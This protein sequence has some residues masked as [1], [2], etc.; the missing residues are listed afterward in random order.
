MRRAVSLFLAAILTSCG[1]APAFAETLTASY[2]GA[3]SGRRTASGETFRP[4]GL[5]A[6]HRTLAFGTRLRVCRAERCVSVRVT[7]RGPFVRGRALDLSAG[8]ARAIGLTGIGVGRVE[9]TRE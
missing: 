2:Y 3:E 9:V 1:P 8:A 4:E 5:T 6:A 7:D